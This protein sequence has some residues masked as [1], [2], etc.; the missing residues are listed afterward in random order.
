LIR[1]RRLNHRSNSRL[2][3]WLL[4]DRNFWLYFLRSFRREV[5]LLLLSSFSISAI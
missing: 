1:G 5:N 3:L 4:L 2:W